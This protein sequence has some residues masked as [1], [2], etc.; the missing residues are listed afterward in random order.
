VSLARLQAILVAL[1]ILVA[2]HRVAQSG[3]R[4]SCLL[5]LMDDQRT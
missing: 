5:R 4:Q 1:Q 2:G 3:F